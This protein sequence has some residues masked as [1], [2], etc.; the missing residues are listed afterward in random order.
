MEKYLRVYKPVGLTPLELINKIKKERQDLLDTKMAYAGRL[1]PMAH[2]E[3]IILLGDECKN[4]DHY[5]GLDKEYQFKIL[6]GIESDTNDILGIL[7]RTDASQNDILLNNS[8]TRKITK[9]FLGKIVQEYPIYSSKTVQGKPLY[10]WARHNKLDQISIPKKEVQIY[11]LNFTQRETLT[12]SELSEFVFCRLDLVRGDF[13]QGEIKNKWKR[14]LSECSR[15]QFTIHTITS[16][17]SSGTYIRTLV[18]DI[19]A[20]IGTRAIAV[21]IFRAQVDLSS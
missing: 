9:K 7:N 20:Y 5:Q 8:Q 6:F 16:K 19:G 14:F 21:D 3:M 11:N 17:V 2:G 1:D 13:R 10:W 4:R 18:K 12:K 15:E